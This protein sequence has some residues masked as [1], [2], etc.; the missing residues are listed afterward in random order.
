MVQERSAAL[1]TALPADFTFAQPGA[2]NGP[3]GVGITNPN[4]GKSQINGEHCAPPRL[5]ENSERLVKTEIRQHCS[6]APTGRPAFLSVQLL[7]KFLDIFLTFFLDFF[8]LFLK[9]L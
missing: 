5:Q 8:F 7:E 3:Q 2:S 4:L 6:N 9:M 1:P